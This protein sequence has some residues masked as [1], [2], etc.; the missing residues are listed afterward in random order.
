MI[1]EPICQ[2]LFWYWKLFFDLSLDKVLLFRRGKTDLTGMNIIIVPLPKIS[3]IIERFYQVS[4]S[5]STLHY[6]AFTRLWM[7]WTKENEGLLWKPGLRKDVGLWATS[8]KNIIKRLFPMKLA[9]A[10]LVI[11]HGCL[12]YTKISW[13]L[14]LGHSLFYNNSHYYV[15]IYP[16]P[17]GSQV[18]RLIWRIKIFLCVNFSSFCLNKIL[19]SLGRR[20]AGPE[21]VAG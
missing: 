13:N 4:F 19:F 2:Y 21:H 9:L 3:K 5:E 1:S 11:W 8:V 16:E 17:N 15:S 12:A 14:C 7:L 6:M 10:K 20:E 18:F